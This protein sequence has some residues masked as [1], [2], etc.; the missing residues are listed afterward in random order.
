MTRPYEHCQ[1]HLIESDIHT[2]T[3]M[4]NSERAVNAWLQI[5]SRLYDELMVQLN[6]DL[7]Q[8]EGP[9]LILIRVKPLMMPLVYLM[10]A[11]KKWEKAHPQRLNARVALL[12]RS[13][14]LSRVMD[15]VATTIRPSDE[16]RFFGGNKEQEA[17]RWLR[18]SE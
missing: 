18:T 10:T 7:S 16:L 17:I 14:A 11:H 9:V 6:G 12:Y 2:F 4:T 3:L 15:R 1:Y 13:N 5:M 8:H